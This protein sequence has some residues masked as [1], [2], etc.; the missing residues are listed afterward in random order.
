MLND[1]QIRDILHCRLSETEMKSALLS[2]TP[3]QLDAGLLQRFLAAFDE[4]LITGAASLNKLG[5]GAVDCTGTGGSGLPH[6]NTSTTTSFVL[7]AAGLKVTKC[8][9]VG[10][11][12]KSGS[13]DLLD[14]LGF[15]RKL[16]LEDIPTLLEQSG[17]VFLY[18][19]QFYPGLSKLAPIR[20]TLGARTI[21]NL[22][23]P[24]LNPA[25]PEYRVL[26]VCSADV[27]QLVAQF[28]TQSSGCTRAFVVRGENGMDELIAD[29]STYITTASPHKIA[30]S[31]YRAKPAS[32]SSAAPFEAT[33]ENN[34]KIFEQ[35]IDGRDQESSFYKM[36]CLNSGA[37]FHV[38]DLASSIEEGVKVAAELLA[39]GAVR[40]LFEK[41]RR[42]YA[43]YL[44]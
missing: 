44:A 20:K 30:E 10:A 13:F 12:S 25:R 38:C 4:M 1:T 43:R 7:A 41:S 26:G 3:D 34:A 27:Q 6:F 2:L 5:S 22:I 9:N 8:G 32:S 16:P 37:A 31:E 36:V 14:L 39:G 40:A 33:P 15:P 18:A 42:I 29:G 21:F 28:L 11:T 23:G 17:L 24:L 35:L 19:P